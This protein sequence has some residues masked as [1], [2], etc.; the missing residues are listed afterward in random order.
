MFSSRG[1]LKDR[2]DC[3]QNQDRIGM[4]NETLR[5]QRQPREIDVSFVFLMNKILLA[6]LS[7]A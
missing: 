2:G 1:L 7:H 4:F 6:T 3:G 5:V